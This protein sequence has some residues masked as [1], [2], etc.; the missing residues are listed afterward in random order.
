[1]VYIPLFGHFIWVWF[2]LCIYELQEFAFLQARI[3]FF[4]G[5][6]DYGSAIGKD[7]LKGLRYRGRME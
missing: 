2:C 7:V 3:V 5:G 6:N 4:T 1:M